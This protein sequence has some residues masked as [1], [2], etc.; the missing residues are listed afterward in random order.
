MDDGLVKQFIKW[1]IKGNIFTADIY[2]SVT[3]IY[4]PIFFNV[5]LRSLHSK[6]CSIMQLYESRKM[7]RLNLFSFTTLSQLHVVNKQYTID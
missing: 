6:H 5:P 7:C 1:N 2:F 3:L 4:K